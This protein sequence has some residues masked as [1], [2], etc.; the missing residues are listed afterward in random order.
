MT[1]KK[2]HIPIFSTG[3]QPSPYLL[4]S[5]LNT[6]S[7][8]VPDN[9][10]F[11]QQ[12]EYLHQDLPTCVDPNNG[13]ILAKNAFAQAGSAFE[14]CTTNSITTAQTARMKT[15]VPTEWFVSAI[16]TIFNI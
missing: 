3:V 16:N 14:R 1:F 9:I 12:M 5:T 6:P 7:I 10:F 2:L 4:A 11:E 15:K 8:I 13:E